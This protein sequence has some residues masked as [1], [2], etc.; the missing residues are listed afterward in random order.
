ML[1]RCTKKLLVE[2]KVEP[3]SISEVDPFF[4]WHANI[5][6][7]NRRKVVVLMNDLNRYAVVLIGVKQRTLKTLTRLPY[8]ESDKHFRRRE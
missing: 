5:L 2:L 7:I 4:S 1:I 6:V 8:K 3:E